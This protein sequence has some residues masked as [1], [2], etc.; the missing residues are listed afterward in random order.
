MSKGIS[1]VIKKLGLSNTKKTVPN[2]NAAII[3]AREI[4]KKPQIQVSTIEKIKNKLKNDAMSVKQ[5][6]V[7]RAK[8]KKLEADKKKQDAAKNV[9][10]T[11]QKEKKKQMNLNVNQ[12]SG[13][14]VQKIIKGPAKDEMSDAAQKV[15]R[16]PGLDKKELKDKGM[17]SGASDF[18]L[19]M[20][21]LKGQTKGLADQLKKKKKLYDD[22]SLSDKRGEKGQLLQNAMN[23]IVKKLKGKVPIRTLRGAG[24]LPSGMA[25]GGLKMPTAN[26]VGLK[27]LP[28]KIRNQMGYM[29]GGGMGKKPRMSKMDYRKGGMVIIALDMKKKGKK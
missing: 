20:A 3:K 24:L 12:K 28:T 21:A 29:Y 14:N 25:Q 19:N 27:K 22:L 23:G 2:L 18:R 11:L 1:A 9:I 4:N 13:E 5:R 7:L 15:L 17:V 10:A 16:T 26:Q 6:D 8:V